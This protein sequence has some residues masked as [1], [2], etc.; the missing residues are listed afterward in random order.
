MRAVKAVVGGMG[1]VAAAKAFGVHRNV[2][3]GWHKSYLAGGWD[4]LKSKRRGRVKGAGKL[5]AQ[6][7][8]EVFKLVM[9]KQPDQ[10]KLPFALWTREAVQRLI[11]RLFK[12]ELSLS[13]VGRYLRRWGF[14]PQKPRRRA[15]EQDPEAA[16]RWEEEEYPAIRGEAKAEKAL[17]YWGDEMGLRSDHQ[18]G[19]SWAKKGQTPVIPGTGQRFGCKVISALTNRGQLAFMVFKE[20]FT[21]PVFLRFMRKL[22]KQAARKIYLIVDNHPVHKARQVKQ[23]IEENATKIRLIFLPGYSPEL[24]PDEMLNN[25]VKSNAVGRK[26]AANQPQL[27]HNVRRHLAHRQSDQD[28][29]RRFFHAPTVRYAAG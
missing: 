18:A 24:N 16:R 29:V 10:L 12:V 3:S 13:S 26:R 21:A 8:A 25:D 9:D 28:T 27:M 14:T 7:A 5:T 6:Q 22:V 20:R 1:Y 17:I 2:V 4:A 19:R 23:W 11:K 15:Y